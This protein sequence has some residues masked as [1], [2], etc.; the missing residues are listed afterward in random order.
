MLA[1][2]CMS[3]VSGILV[4]ALPLV[5]LANHV[6]INC[7]PAGFWDNSLPKTTSGYFVWVMSDDTIKAQAFDGR[8]NWVE[9]GGVKYN[10]G[11]A[12]VNDIPLEK[13]SS[14]GAF[15]GTSFQLNLDQEFTRPDQKKDR[16]FFRGSF[17]ANGGSGKTFGGN[18]E[19]ALGLK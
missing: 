2:K 18:L 1:R 9:F 14:G 11:G 16:R 10:P 8:S 19:C 6:K 3:L 7:G 15:V 13:Y 12:S 17:K 4:L 5:T